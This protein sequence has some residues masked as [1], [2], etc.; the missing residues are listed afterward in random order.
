MEKSALSSAKPRILFILHLPPP[1]HG[2]AVMGEQIRTSALLPAC[3]EA[4]FINLSASETL[5]QVGRFSV[6]KIRPVFR[7][8]DEI[9]R[10]VR[11]WKPDLVYMTPSV[12]M[13]GLLKDVLAIRAAGRSKRLL[14]LHNKGV[15]ERQRRFIL[16]I[17]YRM[18]FQE[19]H[20]ILL[21]R[22]LYPDIRKYVPEKRVSYCA[23]G[24]RVPSSDRSPGSVPR[25]LFLSN[26]IRSKGVSVLIESCRLLKE[27]GIAFR[28]SL[29]G[30]LSADYP[31]DSLSR[32]IREKGLEGWVVYEGPRHGDEK[33]AS[34]GRADVFVHPTL[35]DC[36]PL[37]I[38]EA[39]GTGLPVVTTDEGAIPE[40]VRDG[41]DGLICP[42]DDPVALAAALEQLLADSALRT[43]MGAS[44]QA[45][46]R[47]L[48]TSEQFEKR[49]VEILKD[50]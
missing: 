31:D 36:F 27:K 15:E 29:A 25:L 34:L 33:W 26:I 9:R 49:F 19:A 17:L 43:R 45:R 22:L 14:H 13:P 24:V 3:C 50:A 18:L 21:S 41:E 5:E 28:C 8:V 1:V 46:Y 38:L 39:M 48:F 16:N 10:T 7:L 32:E 35:N 6:R 4:R 44:G 20:V 11:E 47:E 42:K 2:A 37:V 30:A 23:N 40:M 12:T